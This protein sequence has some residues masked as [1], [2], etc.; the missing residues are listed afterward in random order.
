MKVEYDIASDQ[1]DGARDYQEDA[2][3]VNQLG[4]AENGELCS[5][6]I[7]ADGMG[8]HAAGNVASNMVVA[9]FNKSFQGHFPTDKIAEALTDAL[10]APSLSQTLPSP[11]LPLL[12]EASTIRRP[13]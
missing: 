7:M 9:T 12:R 8:G 6:I 10:P 13:T 5:L 11:L 2:Y 4:E 3:M 1:I